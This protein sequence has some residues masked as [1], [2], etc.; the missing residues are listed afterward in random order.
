MRIPMLFLAGLVTLGSTCGAGELKLTPA[1]TAVLSNPNDANDQV[2]YVQFDL[3]SD[4]ANGRI[5][6]A[7]LWTGVECQEAGSVNAWVQLA[8]RAWTSNGITWSNWQA[9]GAVLDQ[10]QVA[11]FEAGDC[12]SGMAIF[13]VSK[14]VRSWGKGERSNFG[15]VIRRTPSSQKSFLF[16]STKACPTPILSITFRGP[17]G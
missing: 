4:A 3:P 12:Q 9:D 11:N 14:W 6:H 10:R 15:F 13:E 1:S 16:A 5:V 2:L 8:P 17:G 7:S